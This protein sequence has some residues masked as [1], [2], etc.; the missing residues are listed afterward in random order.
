MHPEAMNFLRTA[1]AILP[2]PSLVCELGG[3]DVNGTARVLYPYVPLYVGV[4]LLP[5]QGVD[6]VA[7]ARDWRPPSWLRFDLVICTEVLEHTPEPWRICETAFEILKPGG[8]FVVT[9][10]GH[11]RKPHSGIDGGPLR[12]GEHYANVQL[13]DLAQWLEEFAGALPTLTTD[14]ED[15]YTIAVKGEA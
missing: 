9:C 8:A 5:G 10:A 1:K 7:D 3:R 12:E 4:D 14:R 2:R 15:L 11:A 6:V 13:D